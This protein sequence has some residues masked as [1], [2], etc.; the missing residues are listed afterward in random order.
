MTM[1][2]IGPTACFR[3]R[4]ILDVDFRTTYGPARHFVW[5]GKEQYC[6]YVRNL[7]VAMY[8]ANFK[9]QFQ[10][11]LIPTYNDLEFGGRRTLKIDRKTNDPKQ[12][13]SIRNTKWFTF[14]ST[15]DVVGIDMQPLV[16]P[17]D[18]N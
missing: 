1:D 10:T 4:S 15:V 13:K 5:I 17:T 9:F 12:W 8:G 11:V 6:F 2:A 14:S 3:S 16:Q 7:K 18:T